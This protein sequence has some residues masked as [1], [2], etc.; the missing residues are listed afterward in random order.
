[1]FCIF[2]Y[3]ENHIWD[4]LLEW[5]NEAIFLHINIKIIYN[6]IFDLMFKI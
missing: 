3:N 1:M 4:F 6:L 2:Y 5:F